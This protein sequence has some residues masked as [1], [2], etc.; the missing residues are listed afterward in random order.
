MKLAT[1]T[2]GGATKAALV[3]PDGQ[4]FWPLEQM[5]GRAVSDL[6]AIVGDEDFAVLVGTHR[7]RIDVQIGIKFAQ[8]DLE[9][10]RLQK[11]TKCR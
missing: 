11:R 8:P 6:G 7:P 2:H 10:T 1:I 5:L 4:T 3:S 9:S